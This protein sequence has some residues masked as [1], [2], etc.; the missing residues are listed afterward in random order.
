MKRFLGGIALIGLVMSLGAGTAR[1]QTQAF[2]VWYS[3]AFGSGV[4]I[5]GDWATGLN[6]DAKVGTDAPM[7]FGGHIMFGASA[8]K[9]SAGAW[10]FNPRVDG[11]KKPI[12]FGGNLGVSIY[13]G[14]TSPINVDLMAGAGYSK[15]Q[16]DDTVTVGAFE[17]KIW[18]FPVGLPISYGATLQGGHM[19]EP[20]VAPILQIYNWKQDGGTSNTDIGFGVSGGIN[21]YSAMGIGVF[22]VADWQSVTF[23]GDTESTKPFRLGA[24]LSWKFSVPSLPESKGLVGG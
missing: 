23:E 1:A 20:W 4:G 7:T 19:V 18:N 13:K 2:P 12:D 14:A 22:V 6:D 11:L 15:L 24:G 16:T 10:Y 3:P 5:F 9:I 17:T 8:F 21:F